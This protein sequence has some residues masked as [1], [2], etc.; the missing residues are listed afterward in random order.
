MRIQKIIFI[1]IIS[2]FLQNCSEAKKKLPVELGKK[3]LNFSLLDI[4]SKSFSLKSYA[5]SRAVIVWFTNL[6]GGCQANMPDLDNLY[7]KYKSSIEILAI[8]QL[9]E[10]T[11]T[12]KKVITK[13]KPTFPFLIDPS[14]KVSKLYTGEYVPNICPLNNIYFIDKN[15]I[16]RFISHYPGLSKQELE[17]NIKTL[18]SGGK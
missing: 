18:I 13:L 12:V 4:H 11:T 8:S 9:G 14:G 15:G 17:K 3:M 10:D 5:G 2:L 16:I 6:C 7:K 1:L